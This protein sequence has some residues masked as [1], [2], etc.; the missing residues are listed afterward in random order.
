MG[1]LA[2][3][4]RIAEREYPMRVAE[5][6]E[7]RVRLAG[8]MLNDRMK[9]F[10]EQFGVADRQDLLAMVAFELIADKLRAEEQQNSNDAALTHKLT[11]LNNLLSSL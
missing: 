7:E 6:E 2:I 9:N 10:R 11:E 1:E 5:E 4:L 3:K 8:K